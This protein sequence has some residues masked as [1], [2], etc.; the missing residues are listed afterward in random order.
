MHNLIYLL[1][2]L[3]LSSVVSA[4]TIYRSV[5]KDGNVVF[6]DTPG[7]GAE[8]IIL[9]E[10]TTINSASA[11]VTP[12]PEQAQEANVITYAGLKIASPAN[13]EVIRENSGNVHIIVELQPNLMEGHKLTLYLD[14]K[15]YSDSTSPAFSLTNLDRG[16]HQLRVA[17]RDTEGKILLSSTSVTFHLQRASVIRPQTPANPATN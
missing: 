10:V 11:P 8:E 7:E 5:D 4:Q 16:A 17:V 13:D 3:C 1:L 14:S 6:S 9:R 15:E 12:Q 2:A